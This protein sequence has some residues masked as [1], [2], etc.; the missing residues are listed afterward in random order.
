MQLHLLLEFKEIGILSPEFQNIKEG[1]GG[2]I[3]NPD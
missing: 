1:E 2:I 3:V